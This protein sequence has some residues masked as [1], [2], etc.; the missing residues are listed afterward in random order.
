MVI[1]PL[2]CEFSTGGEG[3]YIGLSPSVTLLLTVAE[4]RGRSFADG[5]AGAGAKLRILTKL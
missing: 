2:Q 1:L 4:G 3:E 5:S